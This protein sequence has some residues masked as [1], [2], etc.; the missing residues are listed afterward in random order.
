MIVKDIMTKK[1]IS[2]NSEA[3]LTKLI[4]LIEKHNLRQILVTQRKKLKGI[5]YAKE[6]AKKGISSPERTKVNTIM[7]FTPPHLSPESKIN[8]SA[9]LILKTGLRAL[10]V[11]ENKKV[12]GIV[13]MF[14]IIGAASKM[15][16][17]RQTTA[18]TIMSIPE[19]ITNEDDIGRARLLMREK[20]ISRLPV[21]DKNKK[22]CG[23]VTI[24]DLLKAVKP[25]DRIDFYSMAAEKETIMKIP[26][27]TIMNSSPLIVG[28]G[29]TLNEIVNLMNKY[30]NDGVI[31]AE[32]QFPVG[33]ITA[34][35]L[36]EVY[37]SGLEK[38]G[39]YYQIIGLVDEDEFIVAT[40]DRMIRDAIQKISK[41]YK[42]QFFFLHIK[43]YEKTGKIKYSIRTRLLTNKGAFIS[44]SYAWDLRTAVDE[45][46]EKLE[47]IMFK[48][49]EWKKSRLRER[50][51]FKKLSR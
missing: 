17:F 6:L 11:V 23:I 25:R 34:K 21:I 28:R 32:N 20:N 8:E 37:V 4:S 45:A 31:V 47:R 46:L 40:V 41:V 42:P 27:S 3:T 14:D 43:R 50:L 51:R 19:I 22:L 49:R 7:S 16:E 24:F 13:S 38:K 30:K 18:E 35:D 9:K 2:I 15:K 48:E 10:P 29:A 44:K 36:L 5:I 33:I 12:V 26:I 39:I 1:F